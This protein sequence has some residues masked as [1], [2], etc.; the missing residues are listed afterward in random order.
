MFLLQMTAE[1][2]SFMHGRERLVCFCVV[3]SAAVCSYSSASVVCRRL[4][5]S[6]LAETFV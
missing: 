3:I 2:S 4:G 5:I 6:I 1:Y